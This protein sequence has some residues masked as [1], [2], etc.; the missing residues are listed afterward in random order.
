M[1]PHISPKVPIL[2]PRRG[3][4]LSINDN[5]SVSHA[6]IR[7]IA[8][9]TDTGRAKRG[10]RHDRMQKHMFGLVKL[11]VDMFQEHEKLIEPRSGLDAGTP[12]LCFTG[13]MAGVRVRDMHGRRPAHIQHMCTHGITY[14]FTVPAMAVCVGHVL[15]AD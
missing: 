8:D 11:K 13:F 2:A 10:T 5:Q 12:R 3:V 9:N 7:L 1:H 4:L 15:C 14:I 6:P